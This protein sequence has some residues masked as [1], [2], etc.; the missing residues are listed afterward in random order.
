MIGAPAVIRESWRF[1]LASFAEHV[2]EGAWHAW[3]MHTHIAEVLEDAVLGGNGRVILNVPPRHGKSELGSVWLP[4][5]FLD[6]F[7]QKRVVSASYGS[8]LSAEFGLK[9]RDTFENSDKLKHKLRKDLR[10]AANFR[11]TQGG[12]MFCTGVG[13]GLSGKGADLLVVDDPI[14]DWE[15]AYSPRY[16]ERTNNWWDSVAQTRIEP[17]GSIVVIMTRW[18]EDDLTGYIEKKA[19]YPDWNHIRIPAV[20]EIDDVLSR[21]LGSA[22]VPE[23]YDAAALAKIRVAV[24]ERVW[25]GLY[26][27]RPSAKEGQLFK[28]PWFANRYEELPADID[29]WI[30][31]VDAALTDSATSARNSIV[32]LARK[33]AKLY[34]AD[35]HAFKGE[36]TDLLERFK[37]VSERYPDATVKLV[38]KAAN[39]YGLLNLLE[40]K[41]P[42]L[43]PYEPR[44]S[45]YLRAQVSSTAFESG[46]VLLPERAPWLHDFIEEHVAFPNATFKDIVDSFSQAVIYINEHSAW[47]WWE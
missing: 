25:A 43:T 7:P 44:T 23:R 18:V 38:E 36:L 16:I 2:S 3:A 40:G 14:K 35:L 42:G 34:V 13:A 17:G 5:W 47:N 46:N 11:T 21:A 6:W 12:G 29:Q 37:F 15:T 19:D 4:T 27:Q 10:G 30:I 22:L 33:G 45:K 9:V 20:A 41:V 31:S 26:Q 28:R 24:G 1:G 32:V 8:T 39:G